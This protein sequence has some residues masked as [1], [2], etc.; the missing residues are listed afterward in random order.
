MKT[1]STKEFLE[2]LPNLTPEDVIVDVREVEEFESEHI[3]N[4]L[5]MPLSTIGKHVP[6]LQKFKNIYLICET[7]GRSSYTNEVLKTT[8]IETIDVC[9]GLAS[10]RE[11]GLGLATVVRPN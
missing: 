5:N 6:M 1:I 10:L 9:E 4:S 11:A 3:P 2:V 7:G 8:G